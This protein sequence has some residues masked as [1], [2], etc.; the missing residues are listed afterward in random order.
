MPSATG[1]K[2]RASR[3]FEGVIGP[4]LYFAIG[5]VLSAVRLYRW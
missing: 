2:G 1:L 4:G 3:G 5:A